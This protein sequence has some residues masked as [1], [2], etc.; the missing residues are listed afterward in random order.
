M[1]FFLS[2]GLV[3]DLG[4][5]VVDP[6]IPTLDV[7]SIPAFF[8][9]NFSNLLPFLRLSATFGLLEQIYF[10]SSSEAIPMVPM[11]WSSLAFYFSLKNF[12]ILPTQNIIS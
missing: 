11:I 9:E 12:F 8:G 3:V 6:L 4:S 1:E 2:P 5:N 10:L 7:G